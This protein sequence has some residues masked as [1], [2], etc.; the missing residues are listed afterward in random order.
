MLSYISSNDLWG[1]AREPLWIAYRAVL[2]AS[3]LKWYQIDM[4]WRLI[5]AR[6]NK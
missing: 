3:V 1:S 2:T 4:T 5:V 6:T